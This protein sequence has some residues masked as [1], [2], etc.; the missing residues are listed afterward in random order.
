MCGISSEEI[1]LV[2][3]FDVFSF[4]VK[5]WPEAGGDYVGKNEDCKTGKIITDDA[6]SCWKKL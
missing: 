6:T 5:N 3:S 1:H 2:V 4:T